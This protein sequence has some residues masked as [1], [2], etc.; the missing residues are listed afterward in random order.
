MSVLVLACR[1]AF[2]GLS[3]ALTAPAEIL[4]EGNHIM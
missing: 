4:V 2:A 3:D 1:N